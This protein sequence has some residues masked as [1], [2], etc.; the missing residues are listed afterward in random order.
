[1]LHGVASFPVWH[2]P[3]ICF[4][5]SLSSNPIAL[6]I[7]LCGAREVPSTTFLLEIP[8]IGK[9]LD[10]YNLDFVLKSNFEI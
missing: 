2:T 10:C 3:I 6:Y 8:S 1:M 7:A 4:D 5:K 9:I